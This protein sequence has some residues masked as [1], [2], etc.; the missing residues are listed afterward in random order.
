MHRSLTLLTLALILITFF[1]FGLFRLGQFETTDEHLWKYD[2]IGQY[3]EALQSGEWRETYIN[4]KPGV[5]VAL[6]AGLGL[7]VEPSP[8]LTERLSLPSEEA[9]RYEAYNTLESERIN[10]IFR[11]PVLVLST[12]ALLLFFWLSLVAFQSKTTALLITLFIG[13]NPILIGMAQIINP[14]SFFWIF[15]GLALFSYIAFVLRQKTGLIFLTGFLTGLAL[16]SK[17]TGF[18][19]FPGFLLIL[20]SVWLFL[21]HTPQGKLS[22][23][24]LKRHVLALFGI[25]LTALFTF[26]LLLPA[27]LVEPTLFFKGL[28]QFFDQG[29]RVGLIL[30]SLFILGGLGFLSWWLK[31][32]HLEACQNFF[33]RFRRPLRRIIFGTLFLIIAATL[34]NAWANEAWAPVTALRE[35]A[36]ANEPQAFNFRPVLEKSATEPWRT[37]KLLILEI[38]PLVFSLTPISLTLILLGLVLGSFQ[39]LERRTR[40]ILLAIGSFILLYLIATFLAK[41]VT[42]ARYLI[43]LQPLM[44]LVAGLT[45]SDLVHKYIAPH[46]RTRAWLLLFGIL[47]LIGSF[48]LLT[49]RPFYFSY[50]NPFLPL[51]QSAHDSWGHGSY[52]AAE[53]L[54]NLPNANH[55]VIWSNS[56]TVCRF[57]VGKC[58]RS[59][60][61][62]LAQIT[63]DY[64]VMSKRGVVKER[65]HFILE[66][67]P[68]PEKNTHYYLKKLETD[69]IWELWLNDRPDNFIKIIRFEK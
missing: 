30:L 42:N 29:S 67:N 63:P 34:I 68:Q 13:L 31:E 45:L 39:I 55:L 51:N 7:L 35:A 58:L 1:S 54:N 60:R 23:G 41:V 50:T 44:A 10:F 49:V 17:Y 57:F 26:A 38:H 2:R 6:V 22:L 61:I 32:E 5:T 8:E 48:T 9:K 28:S 59:R 24:N 40:A 4:D 15:G 19:L 25:G 11:F 3:W 46:L 20:I 56:D 14:D 52:E 21:E 27:V 62:D 33:I 43:L 36:Y 64:I 65:N 37:L 66:N 16:L 18:L 47:L 69:P 12:L 53:Y